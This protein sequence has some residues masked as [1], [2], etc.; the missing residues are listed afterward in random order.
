MR[1]RQQGLT[2]ALVAIA[3]LAIL[4]TFGIVQAA[5][6]ALAATGKSDELV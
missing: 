6:I 5:R 3:L 4:A 2:F 1:R